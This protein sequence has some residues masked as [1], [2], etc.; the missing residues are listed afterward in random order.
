M[1][2]HSRLDQ[3]ETC[4]NSPSRFDQFETCINIHSRLDQLETC[5]YIHWL[6]LLTDCQVNLYLFWS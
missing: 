5:I 2:I 1:I 4:I 6:I 3:S